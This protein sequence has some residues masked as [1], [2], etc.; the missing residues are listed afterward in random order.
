[1]WVAGVDGCRIGWIAVLMRV[2]DPQIHRIVTAP[3]LAAI[4]DAP[5]RPA[6]IAVDMPIGLPERTEGSGRVPEQLIRPL[7]GARQSSVFAIPSRRAVEAA[8][9]GEACAIAAA[10]SDPPRKVSRQGF[11]IFPKIREIDALLRARPDL[12]PRIYEVHPELA[13]W[14]LNGRT[15]LDAAEEGE[16]HALRAGHGPAPRA[17]AP[18]RPSARRPDRRRS[19]RGA[20]PRTTCS[21]RLR[22]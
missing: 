14:A 4:A 20:R 7:L 18:V 16:G 21:M 9:Y 5:E 6:V 1:M 15:A 11:A 10:T 2:D 8:D 19:R 12:L 13:F 22:G 17:S 3:S